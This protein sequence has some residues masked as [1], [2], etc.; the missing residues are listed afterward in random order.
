[1][2][3]HRYECDECQLEAFALCGRP[4]YYQFADG[5]RIVAD[6][7]PVW[8]HLCSTI[9]L[10]ENIPAIDD[11]VVRLK[12]LENGDLSENELEFIASLKDNLDD[13]IKGCINNC[14]I[15]ISRFANRRTPNRCIECGASDFIVLG[16]AEGRMPQSIQYHVCKGALSLK[17]WHICSPATF[18]L[19]DAEGNRIRLSCS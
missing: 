9:T 1:M 6:S 3:S 17:E 18:F 2:F 12:Q 4:G 10:A 14:Q 7:L 8:C 5:Q 15:H 13:H 16:D 11:L 19:L